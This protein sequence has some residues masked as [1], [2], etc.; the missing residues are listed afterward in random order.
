MQRIENPTLDQLPVEILL[1][2]FQPIILSDYLSACNIALTCETWHHL[3]QQELNDYKS[4]AILMA[5]LRVKLLQ[6]E[7]T[8]KNTTNKSSCY[9]IMDEF[10]QHC[11]NNIKELTNMATSNTYAQIELFKIYSDVPYKA[12]MPTSE[13]E[14]FYE[15]LNYIYAN[16]QTACWYLQKAAAKNAVAHQ[17]Y[18][19][20]SQNNPSLYSSSFSRKMFE[21]L[22]EVV[23]ADTTVKSP[24]P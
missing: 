1:D 21:R 22:N 4:V 3:L 19:Q 14:T 18:L 20:N 10:S 15:K 16:P 9:K 12:L 2:I 23:A 8:L 6:T 11:E 24:T 5:Q 13:D 17:L 7:Q